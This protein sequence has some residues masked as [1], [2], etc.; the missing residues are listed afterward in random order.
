MLSNPEAYAL[1]A[2]T[3]AG[4][5]TLIG[6]AAC[7]IAKKESRGL[8]T[9]SLGFSGGVMLSVSITDL[10][11]EALEYLSAES[12]NAGGWALSLAAVAAGAVL[13]VLL[14][15]LA[16]HCHNTDCSAHE[17]EALYRLGMISVLAFA[18]HNLPEGMAMFV[19]AYDDVTLSLTLAAAVALHNIPQGFSI[20][21]P[22][23]LGTGS[24]GKAFLYTL[25]AG[26]AEPLGALLAFL[27][28]RPFINENVMG[29]LFGL[30][31][32]ILICIACR[33]LIPASR[34]YGYKKAG[35][36]SIALGI[37]ILPILHLAV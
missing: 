30:V 32:G 19:A 33:E 34:R 15:K 13:G 5:S 27:V 9:I 16:P 3:L 1:F 7:F 31:A 14:E 36:V 35:A 24:R 17:Q 2:A 28:L 22:I 4:L 10:F 29:V 20:A 37:C 23:W 18:M 11:P 26:L 8:V 6:V 21:M 12:G 25:L